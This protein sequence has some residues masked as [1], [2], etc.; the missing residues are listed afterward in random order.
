MRNLVSAARRW[1]RQPKI[2][3]RNGVKMGVKLYVV[4]AAMMFLFG[5]FATIYQGSV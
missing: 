3:I 2:T 1:V 4:V 5:F